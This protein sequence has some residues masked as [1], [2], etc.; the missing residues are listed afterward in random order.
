MGPVKH[1]RKANVCIM[2]DSEEGKGQKI[3]KEIKTEAI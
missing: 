1:H 3:F 2:G